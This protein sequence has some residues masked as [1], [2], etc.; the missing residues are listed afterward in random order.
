MPH[1]ERPAVRPQ[2]RAGGRPPIAHPSAA[3]VAKAP[4]SSAPAPR[5]SN[6]IDDDG[7]GLFDA[8]DPGCHS[9]GDPSN[10]SSY[11]PNANDE[12]PPKGAP[13]TGAVGGGRSGGGGAGGAPASPG[14]AA[15]ALPYT[16]GDVSGAAT[17]CLLLTAAG[18]LLRLGARRRGQA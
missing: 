3:H 13:S 12:G 9:D 4:R 1:R 7:D 16:G 14:P 17:A 11:Q 6:G 8:A 15:S 10:P 2:A 18:L 5:C